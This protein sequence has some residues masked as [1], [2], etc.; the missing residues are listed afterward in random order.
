MTEK[1]DKTPTELNDEELDQVA[2]GVNINQGH[3]P[4]PLAV[5]ID[6]APFT[7]PLALNIDL[8][9]LINPLG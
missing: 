9:Q 4:D 3:M 5:N 1:I 6:Q 7:D 8:D 2:G